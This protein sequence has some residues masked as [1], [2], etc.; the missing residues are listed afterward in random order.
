MERYDNEFERGRWGWPARYSARTDYGY[1]GYGYRGDW[2]YGAEYRRSGGYGMEYGRRGGYADEYTGF[3][4]YHLPRKPA[5]GYPVRG[6]HTY[7]MDYGSR[8]G[9]PAEYSGRAGYAA[10]DAVAGPLS[11]RGA[12]E[13]EYPAPR[14]RPEDWRRAREAFRRPWGYGREYRRRRQ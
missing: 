5:R 10:P 6:I 12:P 3:G 1:S 11:A 7:D 13:E 9:G 2:G 8:T 4:R 14:P